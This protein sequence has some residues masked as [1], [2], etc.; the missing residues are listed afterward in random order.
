[1]SDVQL[2]TFGCAI[3]FLAVA[4]GY[5]AIREQFAHGFFDSVLARRRTSRQRVETAGIETAEEGARS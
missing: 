2:L 1:M 4:G 3:T 5:V